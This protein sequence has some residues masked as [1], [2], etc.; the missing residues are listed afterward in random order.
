VFPLSYFTTG[1]ESF[2]VSTGILKLQ[3]IKRKGR[4]KKEARKDWLPLRKE[5]ERGDGKDEGNKN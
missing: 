1:F 4:K 5:A 2:L 3:F